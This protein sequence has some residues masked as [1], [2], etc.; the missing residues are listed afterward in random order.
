MFKV[1]DQS[2]L[3]NLSIIQ[4]RIV[5]K[6]YNALQVA[7]NIIV[8][9]AKIRCPV[10]TGRLRSSIDFNVSV[11]KNKMTSEIGTDVYYAGYVHFGT[12]RMKARPF[13]QL[14]LTENR[15]KILNVFKGILK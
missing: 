15:Q 1:L 7:S 13:L 11:A 10:K 9:E 3:R 6:V 14:A 12:S 5:T 4:K 2:V 8:D